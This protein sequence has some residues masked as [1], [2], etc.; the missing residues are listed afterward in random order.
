[1]VATKALGQR[2][3]PAPQFSVPI[4]PD[5]L[6]SAGG[7]G[8]TLREIISHIIR[9]EVA[10]FRKRQKDGKL[11]RIL[12]EREMDQQ[13]VRG[14][15]FSGGRDFQR[16]VRAEDAVSTALQAFEDGIYLVI[17]DGED[18]RDLDRQVFLHEGS[19]LMFVRLVM[20]A[21]G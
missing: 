7:E 9:L 8:P 12:T 17:L 20:L 10:A 5:F 19:H 3:A 1:M 14:K 4:P 18:Q 2:K 15:V 21:G 13:A 16:P 6:A 11:V